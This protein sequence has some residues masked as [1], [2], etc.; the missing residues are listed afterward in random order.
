MELYKIGR[1]DIRTELGRGGMATVFHAYDPNFERDVAIKVLPEMF[2]HD[3][4]FRVRFEREAKM[5]ALLEHPAIV[6]VYDFGESNGQPYIVMRYMSGGTLTDRLKEGP[7]SLE[8]VGRIIERLGTALDAA[9]AKAMIHRDIKPGNILFDQYGNAFLSDFGIAHL[10]AEGYA[11]MTGNSTLGTP[12][13]MSPEQVQGDKKIDG[14]SDIYAVGV[15]IYQMLTGH[16]PYESDTPAKIMMMHVLQPVPRILAERPDL[17]VV[18][19]TLITNCMAKDPEDR[20]STAGEVSNALAAAIQGSPSVI[21]YQSTTMPVEGGAIGTAIS[22]APLSDQLTMKGAAQSVSSAQAQPLQR[23][24]F[25]TR[26]IAVIVAIIILIVA[27]VS[28]VML[29]Q[30]GSGPLALLA[31]PSPTLTLVPT[32][33]LLPSVTS[34]PLGPSPTQQIIFVVLPTDTPQP[35]LPSTNLPPTETATPTPKTPIIG[36][37]DKIAFLYNNDVYIA[38]LDGSELAQLTVDAGEKTDLQWLPDGKTILYIKGKCVETVDIDTT[39]L[40][41]VNCFNF[42]DT[43]KSFIVSPDGKQAALS[44]D[45]QLYVVPFDLERLNSVKNRSDLVT[46]SEC[47]DFAPYKRILVTNAT[48]SK[49]MK[50]MVLKIFTDYGEALQIIDVTICTPTPKILDNFPAP[51]FELKNS[52]GN[53]PSF[54]YD[55]N[56]LFVLNDFVRNGGFGDLYSYNS[57]LHKGNVKINPIDQKCCYRDAIFS[58]D[59]QYILFAYQDYLQGSESITKLY[60]IPFGSIGTG[61][62]YI[63]LPLPQ[64]TEPRAAPK[65]VLRPAKLQ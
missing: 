39:R 28:L 8:D 4:Q 56:Y 26:T 31:P 37:A 63:P 27:M 16:L 46:M 61:E 20:F 12:S 62:Q 52:P 5:I 9:H 51:R 59:G 34:L 30:K 3:P 22:K 6:P 1:Y 14:R 53:I 35:T 49:D 45:N 48:W 50:R 15:L 19:D 11:T 33:T 42:T 64:I 44:V 38:N 47:R 18:L 24:G 36:G 2:L 7:L 54:G 32:T 55:G 65:P 23:K 13:Y 43:F 41:I 58:P 17:P 25:S 57:D 29:G 40:E 21:N 60:L 10:T